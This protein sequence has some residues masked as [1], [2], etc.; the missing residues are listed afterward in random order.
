MEQKELRYL[1]ISY[2]IV[3]LCRFYLCCW[4]WTSIVPPGFQWDQLQR[5]GKD[6]RVQRHTEKLCV[7]VC[8]RLH[9]LFP[10]YNCWIP[11]YIREHI[12][13]QLAAVVCQRLLWIPWH[14][15]RSCFEDDS[16]G[17]KLKSKL[18]D[19]VLHWSSNFLSWYFP[20]FRS[21]FFS[22]TSSYSSRFF[23]WHSNR[24][25]GYW[26]HRCLAMVA[27]DLIGSLKS[28]LLD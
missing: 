11:G 22:V 5:N 1:F 15:N 8:A 16:C 14:A 4:Q 23:F 13:S 24:L 2:L 27:D 3:G 7:C 28:L 17:F 25:K 9:C 18:V 20:P 12:S 10:N 26:G 6:K 19:K 21:L